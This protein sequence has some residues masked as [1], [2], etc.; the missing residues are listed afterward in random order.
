ML[1]MAINYSIDEGDDSISGDNA[2]PTE[3]TDEMPE[4]TDNT[5]Q[6]LRQPL[7]LLSLSITRNRR[8]M[9]RI[10]LHITR[11]GMR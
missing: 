9:P 7:T 2:S 4:I 11:L 5:F 8:R 10:L 6:R 3:P 1:L